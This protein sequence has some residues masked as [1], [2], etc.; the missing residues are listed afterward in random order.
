MRP[1][2][3]F[4]AVLLGC[5]GVSAGCTEYSYTQQTELDV[6]QQNRKNAV[7]LLVV[8]DNSCS[9]VEEQENLA[10]N[11]DSLIGTFSEADVQ[12]RIGV[13]TTDVE[14]E[15][16]KGLLIGGDDEII[17]RS[18]RGEVDRVQY[19]RSWVFE[20]GT[21]LQLDAE[22]FTSAT[23]NDSFDAWCA[24]TAA[25]GDASKGTP[26]DWN[27]TCAGTPAEP[28]E[29]GTDDGPSVP[30][31]GDL[32]VTEIMAWS[33][34]VDADCEWLELTNFTDDTLDLTSV[35]LSDQGNNLAALS[36][37]LAPYDSLVVG[38]NLDTAANCGTP[39]DLA[40]EGFVLNHD[41]RFIDPETLDGMDIFAENVAQ[42]TI[43][44]GIEMG[45]EG[46]RLV[47]EEPY[48]S[49][50]NLG[51]L[52]E[53]ANL[54]IL[55]VSD[56]DDVSPYPVDAYQRYFTELKG[57]TA[58]RTPGLVQISAVVGKTPVDR[59][60]LPSCTSAAGEAYYGR[61]YIEM[62]SRTGGLVE[63]ICEEDFAPIV[64]RLGLTLSGLEARFELTTFPRL[65]TLVVRLYSDET[66]ESFI[67]DLLIDVDF[68]YVQDG[69]Y[70][71][72]REEQ[73]PPS[74]YYITAEYEPL[75]TGSLPGT[76]NA[77]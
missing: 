60:D 25:F 57:D 54:A 37:T 29:A 18:S 11:F 15:R 61:R 75:P 39:V 32:V 13:T 58:Y 56:E 7:D 21:S 68:E 59:P 66:E 10:Q 36:G 38:R 71:V 1:S 42:G 12:W 77:P 27:A 55:F 19:D 17:V 50:Q 52:R 63:S 31:F 62:A 45:L 73:V 40:V 69:N 23:S 16:Y 28:P 26:G 49:E 64:E 44:T 48:W 41:V 20:P 2:R 43:G 51:F 5:I 72:F 74:E 34:G 22:R 14:V 35:T 4:K 24:S 3:L 9:M 67:Q 47:F 46:A 6:F 33:A 65:E 8:I 30:G 76:E 53:E 70:L